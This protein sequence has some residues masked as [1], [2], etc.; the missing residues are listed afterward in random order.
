MKCGFEGLPLNTNHI[1]PECKRPIHAVCVGR[2]LEN[3]P[4][5]RDIICFEYIEDEELANE[6]EGNGTAELPT[7]T[8]GGV[9]YKLTSLE[10]G[11]QGDRCSY[12]V[13]RC[14]KCLH[15]KQSLNEFVSCSITKD[16]CHKSHLHCYLNFVYIVTFFSSQM[17][18]LDCAL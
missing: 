6:S 9:T 5:G 4:L 2:H 8:V 14:Y 16:C 1:C 17:K 7:A 15:D 13:K 18:K 10:L 3:A 12:K 11:K